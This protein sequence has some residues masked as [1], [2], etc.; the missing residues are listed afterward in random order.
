[1]HELPLRLVNRLVSHD[2][3]KLSFSQCGEDMIVDFIFRALGVMKAT[4]LDVGAHHSK[5]FSNTYYFYLKGWRGANVEPDPS[6]H[7]ELKR[8]RPRDTNLRLGVAGT[9]EKGRPFFVMSAP[10]L[11][12]F[13]EAEARRYEAT[14]RHR[15][16]RIEPVDV[17]TLNSLF[18]SHFDN[19]APDLLS[20]DVEGLDMEIISSINFEEHRPLVICVETLTYSEDRTERKI[21]EI[22]DYIHSKGYRK[23]ADTYINTIF[24]DNKVWMSRK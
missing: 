6:L 18:R 3:G 23:Y 24:V 20:I 11:N 4:Y 17:V 12:T 19:K 9:E 7:E 21:N 16:I 10:T 14:G 13:S 8:A 1:M 22:I 2:H 15:I 5:L